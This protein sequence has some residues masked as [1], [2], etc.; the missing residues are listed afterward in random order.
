M[1]CPSCGRE[2]PESAVVCS[3]C[4]MPLHDSVNDRTMDSPSE[5]GKHD[6][7]QPSRTE[8]STK[9]R[10]WCGRQAGIRLPRAKVQAAQELGPR[11][12]IDELL[13]EGGMGRV[14]KATD[15]DL[16]WLRI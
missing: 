4:R 3:Q 2:N 8:A 7:T 9:P 6:A 13:G 16:D 10:P 11:F 14:Y 15:R 12:L 5:P 1:K